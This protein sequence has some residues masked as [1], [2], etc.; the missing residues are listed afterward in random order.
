[1]PLLCRSTRLKTCLNLLKRRTSAKEKWRTSILSIV[2]HASIVARVKSV[3][4]L[5]KFAIQIRSAIGSLRC[6]KQNLAQNKSLFQKQV[7]SNSGSQLK[8]SSGT[9]YDIEVEFFRPTGSE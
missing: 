6:A 2:A 3:R 8:P 7:E 1:M 5:V 9:C 4:V